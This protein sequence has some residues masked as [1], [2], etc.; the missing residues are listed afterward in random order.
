MKRLANIPHS[1]PAATKHSPYRKDRTGGRL[2]LM[3]AFAARQEAII[4][5]F[6]MG[7][8][9]AQIVEEL[10][11]PPTSIP[12]ARHDPEFRTRM[13][14]AIEFAKAET[15]GYG[16]ALLPMSM[17][18]AEAT[19]KGKNK[20][21]LRYKAAS[22]NLRG[23]RVWDPE[24]ATTQ[25]LPPPQD[26][27]SLIINVLIHEDPRIRDLALSLARALEAGTSERGSETE[28]GRMAEGK[29]S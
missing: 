3:R 13:D 19:I 26:N 9:E 16:A 10:K 14:N 22:D 4:N 18:V 8:S 24:Q 5:L 11:L 2:D 20:S 27:R 7:Y 17:Q 21:P 28:P 1:R 6:I 23:M 29:A 15:R 25:S 12:N